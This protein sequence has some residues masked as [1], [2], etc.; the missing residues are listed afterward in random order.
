MRRCAG[1]SAP[2]RESAS[3]AAGVT[4]RP[5]AF[6]A[7]AGVDPIRNTNRVTNFVAVIP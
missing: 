1:V 3:A 7:G 6:V 5:R 4:E 2:V